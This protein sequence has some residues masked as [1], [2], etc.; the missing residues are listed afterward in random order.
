MVV[1]TA[2]VPV[3]RSRVVTVD[4]DNA[5]R[6]AALVSG[7]WHLTIDLGSAGPRLR[8][9]LVPAWALGGQER[10][11][12]PVQQRCLDHHRDRVLASVPSDVHAPVITHRAGAAEARRGP[13]TLPRAT[14]S[15]ARLDRGA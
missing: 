4:L 3:D 2:H 8:W 1:R 15:R 10:P 13:L 12:R 14:Q 7:T 5:G 11:G 9:R 6:A